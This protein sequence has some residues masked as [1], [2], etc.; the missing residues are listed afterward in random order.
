MNSNISKHFIDN[1][2]IE[3]NKFEAVKNSILKCIQYGKQD[4]VVC[5]LG[6][7]GIGKTTLHKCISEYL[8]RRQ[9]HGWNI[10]HAYPVTV[11]APAQHDGKF[12][13]KSLMENIAIEL[14]ESDFSK[15]VDLDRIQQNKKTRSAIYTGPA[16]S[17]EGFEKILR[18]RINTFQPVAIFID[19]AQNIVE[20]MTLKTRKAAVNRLKNWA[21][22]MNTKLFLFGTHE[23]KDFLNLNEQLARRILPI[24]FSRYNG[25]DED[26][27][28]EYCSFMWTLID[29]LD[30]DTAPNLMNHARYFYNHS[31]GLPGL[32][33]NWV[34]SA[35]AYYLDNNKTQLTI[36]EFQ[37]CQM[38]KQRLQTIEL[39]IKQFEIVRQN[40][41]GDFDP[42][43]VHPDIFEHEITS[44][45]TATKTSNAPT[46]SNTKPGKQKPVRYPVHD[47]K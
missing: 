27:Y 38:D 37:K 33:A 41:Q 4:E 20:G 43:T 25:L 5:I 44:H 8:I 12:H 2:L 32:F 31:L 13:W 7:T 17:I 22:T 46:K 34:H 42:N 23:A 9:K 6:P 26:E 39:S 35:V 28:H 29:I 3:H 45:K 16:P 30:I 18:K 24:Y 15:K 21:N 40:L 19:E 14:G 47:T 36:K 11:E 1:I 10:D